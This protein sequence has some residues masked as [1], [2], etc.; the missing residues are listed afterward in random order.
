ML[1]LCLFSTLY[2]ECSVSIMGLI[3][4]FG[5]FTTYIVERG[6]K[7]LDYVENDEIMFACLY[8]VALLIMVICWIILVLVRNKDSQ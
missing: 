5:Y 2:I 6:L 3:I 7:C 4:T 1:S 8:G